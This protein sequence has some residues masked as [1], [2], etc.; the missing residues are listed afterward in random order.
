MQH[1]SFF[2]RTFSFA[3]AALAVLAASSA[4]ADTTKM[5][6]S[7]NFWVRISAPEAKGITVKPSS[8]PVQPVSSGAVQ[9][10]DFCTETLAEIYAE[11]GYPEEARRIYSKLILFY[12]EK[13]A[14]FASLI[15]KLK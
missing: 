13:S 15:E 1:Q 7:T 11:Q 6:T 10:D 5:E 9:M 14:Y 2:L 8:E 4:S 12:P 3:L